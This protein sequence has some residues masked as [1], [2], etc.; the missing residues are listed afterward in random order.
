MTGW[1]IGW[2]VAAEAIAARITA[3]HQYLVT[4]ASSVSQ[5]AALAAL[6][7]DSDGERAAYLDIF[8]K[9]RALMG[10]ELARIP[11]LNVTIPDG[12]FYYFLDLRR[13]GSS[14]D[15]AQRLLERRRVITIP[16]EA[17]GPGGAGFLRVS[18]AASDDDIRNGVR[19]L[20]EEL[21]AGG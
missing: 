13:F 1:R 6:S 14:L 8:R 9:R 12:A 3:A 21:T 10:R 16:G 7:P 4:C 2:V 17:F 15:I 20:G 5:A 19:A 18:Y 11:G